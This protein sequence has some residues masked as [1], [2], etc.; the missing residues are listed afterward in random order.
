M[1]AKADGW[2]VSGVRGYWHNLG[3]SHSMTSIT[4]GE[5]VTLW[6]RN[7][8]GTDVILTKTQ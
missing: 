3:I 6:W 4:K 1:D 5:M 7:L 2:G 8:E